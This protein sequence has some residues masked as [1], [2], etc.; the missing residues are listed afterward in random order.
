MIRSRKYTNASHMENCYVPYRV[1]YSYKTFWDFIS[2]VTRQGYRDYID[3]YNNI[4]EYIDKIKKK[5][6]RKIKKKEDNYLK[7]MMK[8]YRN[9]KIF[10]VVYYTCWFIKER[11]RMIKIVIVNY[12]KITL[13]T[14]TE[15]VYAGRNR[16]SFNATVQLYARYSTVS[17][18]TIIVLESMFVYLY[19]AVELRKVLSGVCLAL[20]LAD[21]NNVGT[22]R[23]NNMSLSRFESSV[24]SCANIY[25]SNIFVANIYV[26]NKKLVYYMNSRL[27]HMHSKGWIWSQW[28][29]RFIHMNNW[30]FKCFCDGDGQENTVN[31][32]DND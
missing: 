14:S 28:I 16:R 19:R 2:V 7:P 10:E 15:V 26:F 12:I 9:Y 18:A 25:I 29:L 20:N 30:L 3:E 32:S 1:C 31:W 24:D 8:P 11:E 4:R 23:H 17:L 22:P 21:Q 6:R 27:R 13:S 5:R